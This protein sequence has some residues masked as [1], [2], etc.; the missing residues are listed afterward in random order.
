MANTENPEH[1]H[2]RLVYPA[3]YGLPFL[4]AFGL[5]VVMLMTDKNLQTNFGLVSSGYFSHWYVILATAVADL[6]GAFLLL[7]VRSRTSVKL[8]VLGSGLLAA[9]FVG[10]IFTYNQV[11]GGFFTTPTSFADYLFGI[12]YYGGDI[13]YLY[14]A[15]FGVY[16]ATFVSGIAVL[17]LTRASRARAGAVA[18]EMSSAS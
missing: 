11:G 15:L 3:L 1:A 16:V 10:A 8:G 17:V 9:V 7:F 2:R 4:I 14:D 6:A 18:G 5:S 13:R 12:T